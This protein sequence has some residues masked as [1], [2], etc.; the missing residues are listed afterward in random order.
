MSISVTQKSRDQRHHKDDAGYIDCAM[1]DETCRDCS[2][3]GAG[4]CDLV[5]GGISADGWC[6]YFTSVKHGNRRHHW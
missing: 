4:S 3:F 5:E 1:S 6:R 2:M